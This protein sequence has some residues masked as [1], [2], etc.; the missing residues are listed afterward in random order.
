MTTSIEISNIS[1][2]TR[3]LDVANQITPIA[4]LATIRG[5]RL[6]CAFSTS[7]GCSTRVVF[8]GGLGRIAQRTQLAA[9]AWLAQVE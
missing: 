3:L 1:A 4:V 7:P 8:F 9:D 2:T 6:C 5:N